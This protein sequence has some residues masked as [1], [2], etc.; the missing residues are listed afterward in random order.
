MDK[1]KII[2]ICGLIF[3]LFIII[4]NSKIGTNTVVTKSTST[5][6]KP[7]EIPVVNPVVVGT[8]YN[9]YKA[10]YYN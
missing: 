6:R 10:Q 2:L 8:K 5:Y 1:N 4:H 3:I 7:I 9:P